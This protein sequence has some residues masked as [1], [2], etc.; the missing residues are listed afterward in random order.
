MADRRQH[1]VTVVVGDSTRTHEIDGWIEYEIT[2]S[3]IQPG[4]TFTLRRPFQ[5]DTWDLLRRDSRIRVLI[6]GIQILDG[7]LDA[8][9]KRTRENTIEVSGRD[10]SGRLIQE[11]A[12]SIS[13][14]G[15]EMTEAIKRLATPWFTKVELSDARN[16]KLRTGKG[17]KVPTGNEPI[18]IRS[19]TPGA[20]KVQP[21]QSR[22]SVIEEIVSQAGL[23]CWSTADGRELIV[24]RP[25]Y[26]QAAQFFVRVAR[27]GTGTETTCK[28]LQWSEDNGDRYSVIAVVGAGGGSA[29]DYGAAASSRR[30]MVFDNNDRGPW[31]LA[32]GTGRD[33]IYP[34]RLLM[35][36]RNFD[37]N[38]DAQEIA[39]REQARR[40]F[41]RTVVTAT[42]PMHG[43]F[44]GT[45]AV[46]I[47]APN[48]IA[49]VCDEEFEPTRS[50]D[51]LIYQCSY[52]GSRTDGESTVIEM[53]PRGTEIVL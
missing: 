35:P 14:Q 53:V 1:R 25:N 36:E 49:A 30:A 38:H 16:R 23:L 28:D 48:T 32:D 44:I 11:S 7:L 15:L 24:G 6:D 34:K 52:R 21:G 19:S 41:R 45:G 29:Q 12:P 17:R 27:P 40:D 18:V 3:L 31:S 8:R 5:P 10:R 9:H 22:W 37:S 50:E 39:E 42:M 20:G 2:S 47:F 51:M 33:F 43:Q 46:T 13:Y 26:Q 4:D